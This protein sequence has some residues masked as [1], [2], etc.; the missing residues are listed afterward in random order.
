PGPKAVGERGEI[1][2]LAPDE[3]AV[4]RRL[5]A[6]AIRRIVV[7]IFEARADDL[8]DQRVERGEAEDELAGRGTGRRRGAHAHEQHDGR[9]QETAMAHRGPPRSEASMAGE[10]GG[11][12]FSYHRNVTRSRKVPSSQASP[13]QAAHPSLAP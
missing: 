8:G 5:K 12:L 13:R 3:Q 11:P 2:G 6:V 7:L 9:D 4:R 10:P 1:V